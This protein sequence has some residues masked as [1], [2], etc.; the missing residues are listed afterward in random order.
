MAKKDYYEIL[1]I[2]R[3]A[4][5]D[6]IKKAY[7]K[8]ARKYHPD[9]AGAAAD[10]VEK[11]KEIQE[12][13]EIL[14]DAQKRQAYDQF[15][16]AG[17]HMHSQGGTGWPGGSGQTYQWNSQQQGP[18]GIHF[19]ASDI[20]GGVGGGG[21][22]DEIFE[23]FRQGRSTRRTRQ[24]RTARRGQDL[25]HN[26]VISFEESI[27]GATRDV[28]TTLMEPDGRH[29]QE[30]LTVKIPAGIA[31]GGKIRLK[32]RGQPGSGGN[33]DMIITVAVTEHPYFERKDSDIYLDVPLSFSEAVLGTRIDVPTLTGVTTVTIPSGSSSGQKLRLKERGVK[34]QKSGA[35]GDMFLILKIMPPKN[36]DSRSK[37]LLQEFSD[38]NPQPD[39]R[40]N[41]S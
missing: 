4:S 3:D 23:Q 35:T 28:I 20:F 36:P 34:S 21:G 5:I 33:G 15:G 2:T 8:L 19:D 30:R 24:D 38:R 40:K 1:G 13:Y 29:R 31:N 16:H 6:Q 14:G 25:E 18:G 12:A 26:L 22:L 39:L 27:H 41:W 17:E 37:E 9:T 10:A 11:F 32:G 7:R